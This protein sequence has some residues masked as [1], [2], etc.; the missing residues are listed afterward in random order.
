MRTKARSIG[1]GGA[2]IVLFALCGC[3]Y[4]KLFPVS[5]PLLPNEVAIDR[6]LRL[7]SL[8]EGETPFH[9]MLDI[10]PPRRTAAEMR[11]QVE[12]FWMNPITYRTVIH[13]KNFMQVRIV[14]GRAVEEHNTGDFYPRWIQNFVDGLLQPVPQLKRLR[15]VEGSVPISTASHA[16]ISRPDPALGSDEEDFQARIC[17]TDIDPKLASGSSFTRYVSFDDYAPFGGQQVARTLVNVLPANTLV[18]G[19]IVRLEPLTARDYPLLKVHQS[20]PAPKQ[21]QTSFVP[22]ATAEALLQYPSAEP[23]LRPGG[24]TQEQGGGHM[25]LYIRTDRSGKV[26]EAYRDNS[27]IYGLDDSAV[28]RAMTYRFKPLLVGGVPQQM[29]A[30]ITLAAKP[31]NHP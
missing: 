21:I 29:E 13:S 2:S 5:A 1:L 31:I 27:D 23:W 26:R 17:F 11:A 12:I 30:P 9:L 8:T 3:S 25:T 15:R 22:Q 24:P 7:C 20:T 28:A 19:R 4:E 6:A 10:T 18:N 14:N 16:C